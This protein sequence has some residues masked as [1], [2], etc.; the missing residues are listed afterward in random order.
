MITTQVRRVEWMT[1]MKNR[2]TR[3]AFVVA[4][5]NAIGVFDQPRLMVEAYQVS[6]VPTASAINIKM[7][8]RSGAISCGTACCS[9]AMLQP[10]VRDQ[11]QEWEQENP[12]DVHEVPVQTH[13]LDRPV[14]IG[15]KVSA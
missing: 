12:D 11:I 8:V 1:C 10:K 2:I 7:Y 9:S 4:M 13:H 14:V 15:A 5:I 3:T 6:K